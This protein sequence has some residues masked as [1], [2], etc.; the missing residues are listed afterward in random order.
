MLNRDVVEQILLKLS[1]MP[2][3]ALLGHRLEPNNLATLWR[4][5]ATQQGSVLN[6]AQLS[7]N[8]ALNVKTVQ[9]YLDLLDSMMLLRRLQPWS[10]NLGK[11]LVN[12]PKVYVRDSGVLQGLLN[13]LDHS[14]LINSVAVGA[15]WEGFV[16]EN[17]LSVCPEGFKRQLMTSTTH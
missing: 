15:S 14:A 17:L 7:S 12:G 13:L 10:N 8:T 3:I 1:E 6:V 9:R 11:R 5:I 4:L 2:V 16:I